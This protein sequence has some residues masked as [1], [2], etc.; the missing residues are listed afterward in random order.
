MLL[1]GDSLICPPPPKKKK[2]YNGREMRMLLKGDR[3]GTEVLIWDS[4]IVEEAAGHCF[5]YCFPSASSIAVVNRGAG[6]AFARL[7]DD[8]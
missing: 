2:N 4:L 7:T 6:S 8:P 3:K 5:D 1:K